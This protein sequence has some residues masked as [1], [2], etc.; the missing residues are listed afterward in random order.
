MKFESM[1]LAFPGHFVADIIRRAAVNDERLHFIIE[2]NP[3]GGT[4]LV[5]QAAH[6]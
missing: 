3:G 6:L 2:L 4:A 5:N 1:T